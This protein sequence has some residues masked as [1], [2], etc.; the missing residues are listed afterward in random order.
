MRARGIQVMSKAAPSISNIA[1]LPSPE[2]RLMAFVERERTYLDA[3]D[4]G[5]T[6]HETRWDVGNWLHERGNRRLLVF[7][8]RPKGVPEGLAIPPPKIMLPEP[9]ADF[10][11]ALAVYLQRTRN[12][13]QAA[14]SVYVDDCRRLYNCLYQRGELSPTNFICWD[15]EEAIR[16]LELANGS[17]IYDSAARLQ[18]VSEIIDQYCLTPLPLHFT[19]SVKPASKYLRYVSMTDPERE[20]KLRRDDEKLPSKEALEAYAICTN[21][22]LSDDE[23]VLLRT[24]DLLVAMGQR[25]NEITCIPLDCWVEQPVKEADGQVACDAHG[26]PIVEIGIRYYPEKNFE[27][28]VHWLSDHDVP[29]ARRAV[30]R[31]KIL[32]AAARKVAKWQEMNPGRLWQFAPHEEIHEDDLL[33]KLRFAN[34]R[35]L[36]L[37]LTLSL[38]VAPCREAHDGARKARYYRAGDIEAILLSELGDHV[39]LKQNAK[40]S[41]KIVLRTSETLSIRFDGAF[42]FVRAANVI[43]VLPRVVSVVAVDFWPAWPLRGRRNTNTAYQSSTTS[44][45]EYAI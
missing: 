40:G 17:G 2:E 8:T 15:F 13:G 44:L 27:P 38:K 12:L 20:E 5:I 34:R 31:L 7:T 29:L 45:A 26:N 28:R 4:V 39:V 16:H 21:N 22:P 19:H 14:I 18:A 30:N 6:W 9:F 43:A 3:L 42:R 41:K 25:A 24:I 36:Y 37:H 32:T 10:C 23:E 35:N 33:E 11:K 1:T